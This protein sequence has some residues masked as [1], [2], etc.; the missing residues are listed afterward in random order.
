VIDI[1][2]LKRFLAKLIRNALAPRCDAI[3]PAQLGRPIVVGFF[4]S[5]SGIGE[6][7]RLCFHALTRAGL[8]PQ[9]ID[10]TAR[11]QAQEMIN[12]EYSVA[13][14]RQ[15]GPIILHINPPEMPAIAFYLGRS[16]FRGRLVV[17]YW[18]WE[19]EQVPS[20]WHKGLE[21]VH[22]IWVPSQFCADAMRSI[23]TKPI[24]VVHHPLPPFKGES[25]RGG[26]GLPEDQF[27][28]LVVCD[29]R[30]GIERK[31]LSG[32]VSAFRRAFPLPSNSLLIVKISGW[33]QEAK[34][35]KQL[36]NSLLSEN[37]IFVINESLAPTDMDDLMASVDAVLS[38][39]RC[40]GFGLILARAM[41]AGK[42]IIATDWSGSREF[43]KNNAALLVSFDL[44]PAIDP[45]GIYKGKSLR[46][47]EPDIE[48]AA[49]ALIKLASN[50]ELR[51]SLGL[52][53]QLCAA[54]FFSDHNFVTSLG[55]PF[56]KRANFR[57]LTRR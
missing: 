46:W 33:R 29:L 7:A 37:D 9:S 3:P 35:Y 57:I 24:R 17:G 8:H 47:A 43:L 40:E 10:V 55:A 1:T 6:S 26:F 28:V 22:E 4:R 11:F 13:D 14:L 32:S 23:T 56:R 5:A 53:A 42:P 27:L 16:A 41:Q 30:S 39:H 31:N 15:P 36:C 2:S 44:I 48:M 18:A 19:F 34:L 50:A 49:D 21:F 25:N 45:Q 38:L 54:D 51:N 12:I 20:E 52:Q